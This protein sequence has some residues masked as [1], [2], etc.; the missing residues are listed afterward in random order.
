MPLHTS[1]SFENRYYSHNGVKFT[2]L[3][4]RINTGRIVTRTVPLCS[5]KLLWQS[6]SATEMQLNYLRSTSGQMRTLRQ[7]FEGDVEGALRER[8]SCCLI[9]MLLARSDI[10]L[11]PYRIGPVLVWSSGERADSVVEELAVLRCVTC[12]R[13]QLVLSLDISSFR[14]GQTAWYGWKEYASPLKGD[15][16][17]VTAAGGAAPQ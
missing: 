8:V 10:S 1:I 17:Y 5:G 13:F 15:V 7:Q 14:P 12:M 11:M 16:V 9:V 3:V 2:F 6:S 4:K